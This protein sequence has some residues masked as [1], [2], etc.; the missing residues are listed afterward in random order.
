M[1][2]DFEILP[3]TA[4]LQIRAYGEDLPTLFANALRGM[5]ISIKPKPLGNDTTEHPIEVSS[6]DLESLLVDFLSEALYLSDVYKEAYLDIVI[7]EMSKTHIKGTLKGIKVEDFV[8]GE[9]KAVTHHGLKVEK[10]GSFWE[11]EI[12]FDL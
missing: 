12:L 7:E 5:F 6:H 4:D 11:A 9:I 3:H 8:E 1:K 10:K 2:K